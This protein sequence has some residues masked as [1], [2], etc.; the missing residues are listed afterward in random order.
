MTY[1]YPALEV[2]GWHVEA[3]WHWD[4]FGVIA[5]VTWGQSVVLRLGWGYVMA[6]KF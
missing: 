4:T 2:E 6:W 1:C 3:G 5:S